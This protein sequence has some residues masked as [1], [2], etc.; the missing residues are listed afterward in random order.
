MSPRINIRRGTINDLDSLVDLET[1]GF[2]ADH[3]SAE[4]FHY[5]LTKANCTV[6]IIER[7]R[8]T[9]GAAILLWRKGR[10]VSRLYNIVI[11]PSYQSE[12][13]GA[14]LLAAC[15]S[16]SLAKKCQK[17]SLE[18]RIDNKGGIRFYEKHG[19]VIT[20]ELPRYYSGVASGYRMVKK[21]IDK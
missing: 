20:E 8:Q 5:L 10:K 7:N 19:F 3:Y 9:V 12:G 18:V 13:L 17:L 4:Q 1:R 6:L 16:E 14:K 15:E 11:D 2:T 21:L